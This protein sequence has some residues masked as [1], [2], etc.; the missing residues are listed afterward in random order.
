M[1]SQTILSTVDVTAL[2]ALCQKYHV[3]RLS[4]FGS[5]AKG[6]QHAQSDLDLLVEFE[7]GKTPGLRFFT[8]QR[9]LTSL[10]NHSV[11]LNTPASLHER[12]RTEVLREA[13]EIYAV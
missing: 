1:M 6:G 9:A 12:F 3:T 13:K 10:F 5:Y 11:D 8:L 2:A 7:K 4:L